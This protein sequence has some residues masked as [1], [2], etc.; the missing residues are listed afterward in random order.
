VAGRPPRAT[1]RLGR[2]LTMMGRGFRFRAWMRELPQASADKLSALVAPRQ[3]DPDKRWEAAQQPK[4]WHQIGQIMERDVDKH[5]TL[6][7]SDDEQA[8]QMLVAIVSTLPVDR[9]TA[10]LCDLA[11]S[12]ISQNEVDARQLLTEMRCHDWTRIREVCDQ[13]VQS[14]P[15][16]PSATSKA[17]PVR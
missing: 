12:W 7:A 14:I 5:R 4:L 15:P 10:E 1:T 11:H 9:P 8:L 17:E 16:P 2:E 13:I 6:P 3:E